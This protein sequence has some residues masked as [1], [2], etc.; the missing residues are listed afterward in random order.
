MKRIAL[1]GNVNNNLFA[2]TRHLRDA[3]YDAH[4]FY[5]TPMPHFH[6]MADT[7]SLDYVNYCHEVNW[8]NKNFH[9]ADGNLVKKQLSDFDFYIGQSDEAAVAYRFGFNMDVYYPYGSDV[10]KY[11]H[12]PEKFNGVRMAYTLLRGNRAEYDL[13]KIGTSARFLKGAIADARYILAEYRN[14][15]YENKLNT[16]H[17]NGKYEHVPMPFVYTKEYDDITSGKEADVHWKSEMDKMRHNYDFIILYH[18]RQ[19]WKTEHNDF[20]GKNT[21]H[22]IIGFSQYLQKNPAVNICL[23]MIEYGS[24][25]QYSKQLIAD[26]GIANKVK[27]FPKMYRKDIMYL[28]HNVDVCCGEFKFSDLT[29]GT[30][31]EAM[32]MGKPVIHHRKD[33]MFTGQYK[34]LYPMLHAR[35]PE[36]IANVIDYAV[37]NKE[38]IAEIGVTAKAWI[39]KNFIRQPL[40]HLINIIE[41][42]R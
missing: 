4:L 12:L 20:T 5:R 11:A 37:A 21:H 9:Y 33:E 15:E 23:C 13:M 25:V 7:Y 24:D 6:P 42:K 35:E 14:E 8:L 38:P 29:F 27:W 40:Q 31:V 17:Y 18:G 3:G 39:E 19:E 2:I 22:L 26:L 32:I 41:Q 16:L 28:I 30:I 10:Y 36:E 34:D 1:V